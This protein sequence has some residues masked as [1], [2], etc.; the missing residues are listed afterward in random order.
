MRAEMQAAL[1]GLRFNRPKAISCLATA[2]AKV[3]N[4]ASRT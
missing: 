3:A 1:A 4:E 2:R